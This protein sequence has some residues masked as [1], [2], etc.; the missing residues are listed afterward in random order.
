MTGLTFV[1]TGDSIITRRLSH[2]KDPDFLELASLIRGADAAF[3]NLELPLPKDPVA[4][5]SSK[6]LLSAPPY[7]V[8]ELAWMGLNLFSIANNHAVDYMYQGLVDTMAVL[9][10]KGQVFAGAGED[11]GKARQPG[12]LETGAGRVALVAAATPFSTATWGGW[13]SESGPGCPGRPGI[14]PL[15]YETRY[16]LD[17]DR[18]RALQEIDAALGTAAATGRLRDFGIFFDG[19]AGALPFLGANFYQGEQPAVIA[20]VRQSD[21]DEIARWI[22]GAGKQADLAAVSLHAHEGP[23]NDS[24]S[25][26]PAAFVVETAHTWIDAGA[27]IFIGHGPHM[28]RPMEIYKGKPIFYSLGN[29]IYMSETLERIPA[30]VY[31]YFGLTPDATPGELFDIRS[32]ER[33]GKPRGFHANPAFWEAIVP[34]ARY[35]DRRLVAL[36][37]H[38]ITLGLHMPRSQRGVPRLTSFAEGAAILERLA[39]MSRPYGAEIAVERRGERAVGAVRL[40]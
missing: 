12:Y 10:Q 13:A 33:D 5:N 38:P 25:P 8:D 27:D 30:E 9:R 26:E 34:V 29:F 32:G 37:L 2:L 6:V 16:V 3:N 4:P 7:V 22:R 1:A 39:G 23:A 18:F 11:L 31:R 40:A 20:N 15:R 36:D 35:Q 28:L 24:N 14:N 21:L 17:A 19:K